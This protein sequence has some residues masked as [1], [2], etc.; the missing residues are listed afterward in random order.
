MLSVSSTA[1]I[2]TRPGYR[3]RWLLFCFLIPQ[4]ALPQAIVKPTTE[5]QISE[6]SLKEDFSRLIFEATA[7]PQLPLI[8]A[9]VGS[10][11][12]AIA[13]AQNSGAQVPTTSITTNL[14]LKEPGLPLQTEIV[15]YQS[16]LDTAIETQDQYSQQLRELYESLGVLL[17]QNGEHEKAITLFEKAMHIDRVNAGLFTL[18]QLPI[19]ARIITSHSALGNIDEVADFQEYRYYVQQKFY[20]PTSPEYLAAKENWADWN[21]ESYLKETVEFKNNPGSGFSFGSAQQKSMDYIPIQ[22]PKNGTFQYVP[23]NQLHN[24]LNPNPFATRANSTNLYEQSSLYAISPELMIDDRLRKARTLYEDILETQTAESEIENGATIKH[25]LANIS[26][27]VKN[28]MDAIE[29]KSQESS[30]GFTTLMN[31]STPNIAVTR[32]YSKTTE[33]LEG[34]ALA[35]EKNPSINPE[36]VAI[37]YINLGDWHVSFERPQR[38]S[39]AYKKAWQI[40]KN[41]DL[42]DDAIIRIFSPQPLIAVPAYALHEY[43]R[44]LFGYTANDK[45]EYRGYFDT[46]VTLDRFGKLSNIQIEPAS[47]DTPPRLRDNLLDYL[48]S[49]KMRPAIVDGEPIKITDLKIRYYYSY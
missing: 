24:L 33:D 45:I 36:E 9:T 14:L 11:Q 22:N 23:R 42:N 38:S 47:P 17:Q 1:Q 48:R 16:A 29:S 41:A 20:A 19:V 5:T 7:A 25:K 35:L 44:A 43:S 13:G 28:Q 40:L 32:G 18:L 4:F 26:Y 12:G 49:Q 21:V 30:L 10:A 3:V 8:G 37:A 34:I 6:A 31:Q 2:I 15:R 39:T 27:A 46:S